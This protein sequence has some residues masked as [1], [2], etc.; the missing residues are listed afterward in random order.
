MKKIF[1]KNKVFWAFLSFSFL[2]LILSSGFNYFLGTNYIFNKINIDSFITNFIYFR[3]LLVNFFNT[4]DMSLFTYNV[5]LGTNLLP[6]F[7][8]LFGDLLSYIS[9][10]FSEEN[11]VVLFEVL[12]YIRLFLAGISFIIYSKYK[13]ISNYYSV[14]GAIIYSFS[15]FILYFFSNNLY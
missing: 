3:S 14:I 7:I 10:V 15:I 13:N 12:I 9:V 6:G 4:G 11:L 1:K 8:Y 2:F 5:G